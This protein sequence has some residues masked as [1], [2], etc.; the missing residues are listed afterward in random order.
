MSRRKPAV[1]YYRV[2]T[3]KQGQSG[4]GLE[5][6]QAAVQ[7]FLGRDW[8]P[9]REFVEIESGRKDDRPVLAEA[10]AFC[11]QHGCRLV[12]AKLDRLARD[13]HFVSGLMKAGVEFV[14]ADMPTVNRLTVHVV[15]AVA[16]EE[17][18][19]TSQRTKAALAAWKARNPD[20]RL[21]NP[22]GFTAAAIQAGTA[23]RVEKAAARDA[24]ILPTV[25]FM[26]DNGKTLAQV[27]AHLT[28]MG[29]QTP[30]GGPWRPA[31]VGRVLERLSG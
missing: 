14:A 3:R 21:G 4:L 16:E 23:K 13:V 31:Q 22:N 27:A 7:T 26:R 6:Q 12:I 5:A 24:R 15:A 19:A 11:R 25:R 1:A 9:L 29:V 30:R 28:E 8:L 17:A 18:R 2:S 10:L 20:R